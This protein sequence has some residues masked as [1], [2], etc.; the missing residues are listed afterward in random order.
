MIWLFTIT[1]RIPSPPDLADH[2]RG[3]FMEGELREQYRAWSVN[4][5]EAYTLEDEHSALKNVM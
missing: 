3:L 2:M 5:W 1:N 4:T